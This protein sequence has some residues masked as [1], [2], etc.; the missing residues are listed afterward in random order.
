VAQSYFNRLEALEH[1]IGPAL[2]RI[3]ARMLSM[4]AAAPETAPARPPL[5]AT[6]KNEMWS[7]WVLPRTV[8]D[9]DGTTWWGSVGRPH[10]DRPGPIFVGRRT[11]AGVV[12]KAVI[13]VQQENIGPWAARGTTDDHNRPAIIYNPW[14]EARLPLAAIQA[15]HGAHPW[16]RY[17][18]S[19]TLDP[20]DLALRGRLEHGDGLKTY[21]QWFLRPDRPGVLRG[22]YRE[23]NYQRA[24][25][26]FA[27][28]PDETADPSDWA[29]HPERLVGRG[30]YI[31]LTPTVSG[32]GLWLTSYRLP[33]VAGPRRITLAK[34]RW[35]W[36][37]VNLDGDVIVNDLR[38]APPLDP[39][40]HPDFSV[41]HEAPETDHIR[42]FDVREREDGRLQT[43]E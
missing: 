43:T 5:V 3:D 9:A 18:T 28:R 31:L 2:E 41:A 21:G 20:A 10:R 25:W 38:A 29:F 39:L 4:N 6:V 12:D 30:L 24:G 23:G 36:S 27:E 15:D 1:R 33:S 37:L 26:S 17:W 22:A 16:L 19:P 35:D 13:G 7:Q 42:L 34:L 8:E 11:L 14:P 40:A 32:D